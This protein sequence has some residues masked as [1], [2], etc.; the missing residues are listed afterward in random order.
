M[1]KRKEGG[2]KSNN[3]LPGNV[4]FISHCGCL[5]TAQKK[6]LLFPSKLQMIFM[7]LIFNHISSVIFPSNKKEYAPQQKL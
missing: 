1:H 6:L 3:I 7:N 4:D 5:V 2:G